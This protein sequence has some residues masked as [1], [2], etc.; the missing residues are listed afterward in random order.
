MNRKTTEDF[1][2]DARIVHG[3]EYDYSKVN[4]VNARTK[5]C[6]LH[7]GCGNAFY[8][9]PNTHLNG[10]GCPFCFGTRLMKTD[11][12]IIR[13]NKVHINKYDYTK[14]EY[15]GARKKLC[16]ICQEHGEFWQT[17]YEHLHGHGC[18]A[19][20]RR[21]LVSKETLTKEEFIKKSNKIHKG[22]YEYSDVEYRNN[23]I[24]VHILCPI[25]GGF[26]QKPYLHLQGCGCPKC[27]VRQS[28]QEEE[29]FE[30]I[31]EIENTTVLQRNNNIIP[32]YEL[33]IYIPDKHIAIEYDGLI[34]HSDKFGKNMNYHLR[35]TS[36]CA[37][38]GIHLI[39]IF[40]DEWLSKPNVVKAKITELLGYFHKNNIINA[41]EIII[42][43]ISSN[44]AMEFYSTHDLIPFKN[45]TIHVGCF[46]KN[47]LISSISFKD[48]VRQEKKWVLTHFAYDI[49]YCDGNIFH[50]LC[51]YFIDKYEATEII[52]LAD[53]R[54]FSE[55]KDN[56]YDE[57][58]FVNEQILEPTFSYVDGRKRI[59]NLELDGNKLPKI[60]NCGYIK[61]IWNKK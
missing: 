46:V 51:K 29:L 2:K 1:I 19:C 49:K 4:Y 8:Q 22:K 44:E 24:K 5:V 7:N 48:T 55:I 56:F 34:W 23:K 28:K 12:F 32:P 47:S 35:K 50:I 16:I 60:W 9:K 26:W 54:W 25:H 53:M 20:G 11:D 31:K 27:G 6:I 10:C 13:A 37:E 45:S 14:S 33:D 59:D 36:I 43:P 3:D 40:E 52:A 21:T 18:P 57:F 58:G 42:S 61:Y 15:I 41:Y 39:H 30:F 17:A 38:K